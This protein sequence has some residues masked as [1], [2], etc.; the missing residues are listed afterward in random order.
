MTF[1]KRIMRAVRLCRLGDRT[2]RHAGRPNSAGTGAA[3]APSRVRRVAGFTGTGRSPGV[4]PSSLVALG[5]ALPADPGLDETVDVAVEHAAGVAH[6]VLGAQ[7]LDHLVGVQDVRAHLVAP[8][9]LDVPGHGLLHRVLLGLALQQQPGLQDAKGRGPVLDLGLLV[10]HRDHDAGGDVRHTHGRVG[11][12]DRLATGAAGA[13]DI[14]LDLVVGDLDAVRRLD[15]RDD[16]DGGERGLAPALVVERRDAYEAVGA[17]LDGKIAIRVGDLD[18][19][20][21]RLQPGLL[22]VGGVQDLGR[23]AVP[24]RPAQVHP[25]E[26]LGEVRRIDTA[27]AGA[28]RD[29]GLALVVLA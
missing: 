27:G 6:L 20:G 11:G 29:D 5:A 22:G 7:V 26:H 21:S 10:L 19:E 13:E 14:D 16:L 25:H 23:V 24:I 3:G 4:A 2:P 12:V 1:S 28:D 9:R 18:L 15:Q 17:G 8:A